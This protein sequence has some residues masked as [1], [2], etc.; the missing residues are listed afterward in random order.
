IA[1]GLVLVNIYARKNETNYISDFHELPYHLRTGLIKK[2]D[3]ET[4]GMKTVSSM[5]VDP[6]FFHL[7]ILCLVIL[8]SFY[9]KDFLEMLIPQIN[10]PMLSMAYVIGL[11]IQIIFR[12]LAITGYIDKKIIDSLSGTS[13]DLLVAFG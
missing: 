12:K 1:G 8:A 9:V 5:A 13:T 4:M 2:D 3:R 7:A 6:L 11:L 10:I